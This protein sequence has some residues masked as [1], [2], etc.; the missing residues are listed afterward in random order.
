[1]WIGTV[2]LCAELLIYTAWILS[3]SSCLLR[4]TTGFAT[5]SH[6]YQSK[7]AASALVLT[8]PI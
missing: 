5:N 3:C 2:A 8:T 1:M 7:E 6:A 4:R